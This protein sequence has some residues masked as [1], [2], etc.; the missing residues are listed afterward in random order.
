MNVMSRKFKVK[1]NGTFIETCFCL[2]PKVFMCFQSFGMH[3]SMS[4]KS[5]IKQLQKVAKEK[6]VQKNEH[7]QRQEEEAKVLKKKEAK[8]ELKKTK[9]TGMLNI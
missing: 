9:S 4:A 1:K 7:R 3:K 8:E 5:V 2:L 6:E